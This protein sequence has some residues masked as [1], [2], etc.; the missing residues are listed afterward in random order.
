M[1]S[2]FDDVISSTLSVETPATSAILF[3]VFLSNAHDMKFW[4]SKISN[5][6]VGHI[7]YVTSNQSYLRYL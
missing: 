6:R 4:M 3:V 5:Q 1:I 2:F 7:G